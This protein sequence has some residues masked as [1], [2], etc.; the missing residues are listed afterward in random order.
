MEPLAQ[1]ANVAVDQIWHGFAIFL[2]VATVVA[3]LP[4]FGEQ[5]VPVRIKLGVAFAFT[6]IVAPAV[7]LPEIDRTMSGIVLYSLTEIVSGLLIGI[8]IRLFVMALQTAGAIAAQSTSLSQLLG[9]ASV[10]PL[11]AIGYVLMIGGMALAVISGLHVKA[12]Q[13]L[14]LTYDILPFGLF[15]AGS[16]VADWG[17]R[18]VSYVFGLAFTLAAPFVLVSILYNL[19]LGVINKAMPQLMVAFVG[20]PLITAGGL[21]IL[22]ISA[23]VLLSVW[24]AA[25]D[26]FLFSPFGNGQ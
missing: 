19:M 22:C 25:L 16:D 17:T 5:S 2:R 3:L 14:I 24:L 10:E 21:F 7:V 6:A 13:M 9:G 11:A 12:A 23:P 8:G 15:A 20:A 1:L 26:G 18:R 4:A